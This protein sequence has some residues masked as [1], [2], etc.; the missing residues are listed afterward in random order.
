[1]VFVYFLTRLFE[2]GQ[3]I[4]LVALLVEAEAHLAFV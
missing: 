2:E 1:V 3:V 4:Q